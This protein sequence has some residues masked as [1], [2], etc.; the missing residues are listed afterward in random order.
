MNLLPCLV[1]FTK[2]FLDEVFKQQRPV[3]VLFVDVDDPLSERYRFLFHKAANEYK[4]EIM[5]M[6]SGIQDGL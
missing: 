3:M 5:F 4:D 1:E 2:D 6:W